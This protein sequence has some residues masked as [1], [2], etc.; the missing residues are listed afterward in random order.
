MNHHYMVMNYLKIQKP[1]DDY[2]KS[3]G[4]A[5]KFDQMLAAYLP[6]RERTKVWLQK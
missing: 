6:E 3:M 4:R 1:V 5:D 2:I